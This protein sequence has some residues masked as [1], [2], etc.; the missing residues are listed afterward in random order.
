MTLSNLTVL[1]CDDEEAGR[2]VLSYELKQIGVKRVITCGSADEVLD[3]VQE[4]LPDLFFLDIQMPSINGIEL[5]RQ[6]AKYKCHV[7]FVTAYV[8][9]AAESYDVDALDFITKPVTNHKLMR[10][11]E[12]SIERRWDQPDK[13]ISYLVK[14]QEGR[15]V[16]LLSNTEI[17]C[18][19]AEDK[20]VRVCANNRELL[21]RQTISGLQKI[22][23]PD[24]IR[25]HRSA[26][27]N[28]NSIRRASRR[29][30]RLELTLHDGRVLPVGKTFEK[31]VRSV[32]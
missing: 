3:R 20:Y 25:V 15:H 24:F 10:A 21:W 1:I 23:Q 14:I 22:L 30:G 31:D 8:G 17:G 16:Q 11:L 7:V 27:V 6:L 4:G 32:L 18:F 5:A 29:D 12:R 26:I 13:P 19:L 2:D 9:F 28:R